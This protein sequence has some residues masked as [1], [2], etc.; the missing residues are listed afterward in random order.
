MAETPRPPDFYTLVEPIDNKL[1]VTKPRGA[2]IPRPRKSAGGI[3]LPEQ[4]EIHSR[5]YGLVCRVLKS[6]PKCELA[7]HAGDT[8]LVAEFAGIPLFSHN[9][10]IRCWLIS[11]AEVLAVVAPAV[12]DLFET[13]DDDTA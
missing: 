7:W 12:W 13:G 5:E 11:E 8:V 3:L 6:G 10:E 1:V 4:S 2:G 9:E